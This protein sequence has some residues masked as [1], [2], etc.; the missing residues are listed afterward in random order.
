MISFCK[1]F[2]Y[3]NFIKTYNRAIQRAFSKAC[4]DPIPAGYSVNSHS[5]RATKATI[6]YRESDGELGPVIKALGHAKAENSN[7]YVKKKP[8]VD[9]FDL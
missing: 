4:P 2:N 3:E 5:I 8:G 1:G 7:L 9:F 6:I